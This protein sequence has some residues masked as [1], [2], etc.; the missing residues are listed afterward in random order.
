MVVHLFFVLPY[1]FLSLAPAFRGWD[2]RH[3]L[4]AAT[5]GAG[6]GRI[7]WRLRL[8]MLLGPVLTA[9]ALGVAV[10]AGQYLPTLM[11]GGGRVGTLTTEA[12]ALSSG[13]NRRLIGVFAI[14]QLA[15]P[16]VAFALALAVPRQV[17]ANRRA[18]LAEGG[19]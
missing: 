13:G 7:F 3:S 16:A 15:L 9:A 5:L 1:V 8:P 18:M 6:E 2:R 19:R 12:V 14:A 17:F 4:A 11:V 10:S